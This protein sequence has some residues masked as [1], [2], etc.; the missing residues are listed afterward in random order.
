MFSYHNVCSGSQQN[1]SQLFMSNVKQSSS[2]F[3]D[4]P[5]RVRLVF[6]F[7]LADSD[8]AI[9]KIEF[10]FVKSAFNVFSSGAMISFIP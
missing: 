2:N 4:F 5:E 7:F 8:L 1:G 9:Y 10:E 3:F 6:F